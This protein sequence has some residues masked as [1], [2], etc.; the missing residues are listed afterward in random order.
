MPS[1]FVA[2]LIRS[3]SQSRSWTNVMAAFAVIHTAYILFARTK[4]AVL[5]ASLPTKMCVTLHVQVWASKTTSPIDVFC[6]TLPWRRSVD[7]KSMKASSCRH[8]T[9]VA[10]AT[11]TE[12][13][14]E[15]PFVPLFAANHYV[16]FPHAF[17]PHDNYF[18]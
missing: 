13:N 5:V 7:R 3:S 18:G 4:S 8:A 15:F 10:R 16:F 11:A 6:P 2:I 1:R 17:L 14:Y 12:T 9:T